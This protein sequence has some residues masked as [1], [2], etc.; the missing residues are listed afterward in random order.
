MDRSPVF[1]RATH[2]KVVVP[3]PLA[4]DC[5]R[6]VGHLVEGRRQKNK[7]QTHCN[8]PYFNFV[9]FWIL[10]EFSFG[11]LPDYVHYICLFLTLAAC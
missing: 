9:C 11:K 10:R 7:K 4:A 8:L 2:S 5:F 6:P 3:D 1:W